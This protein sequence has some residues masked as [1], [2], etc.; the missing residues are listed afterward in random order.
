MPRLLFTAPTGTVASTEALA[1]SI[2]ETLGVPPLSN[3]EFTTQMLPNPPAMPIGS[4]PTG[5]RASTSR[6]GGPAGVAVGVDAGVA[7][8]LP[9]QA[10]TRA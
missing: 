2:R 8:S 1:G 6:R 7:G 5:T 4:A 10:P 9:P 3:S